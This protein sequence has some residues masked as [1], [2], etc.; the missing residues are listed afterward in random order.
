MLWE[1]AIGDERDAVLV[2]HFTFNNFYITS[3]LVIKVSEQKGLKEGS[4]ITEIILN[5]FRNTINNF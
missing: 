1:P 2:S 4:S 3:K 5:I